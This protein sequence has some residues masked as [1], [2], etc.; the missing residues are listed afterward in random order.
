MNAV[1]KVNKSYITI[2]LSCHSLYMTIW[3]H[4]YGN[5]FVLYTAIF[6]GFKN[7]YFQMKQ[8]DN[9]IFLIFLIFA[10]NIDCGY[11]LETEA[12][13]TTTHDL[14]FRAKL[15]KNAFPFKSQFYH[16]KVVCKGV[17]ITRRFYHNVF[18]GYQQKCQVYNRQQNPYYSMKK[19]SFIR[20]M[21]TV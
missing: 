20:I 15:R 9:I 11:T 1:L 2:V 16:L 6:H 7:G 4:D 21:V 8:Y 13:L 3:F 18:I 17:F 19:K 12:V 10:Q 5:I 14:C